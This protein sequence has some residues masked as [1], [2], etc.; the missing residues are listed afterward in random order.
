MSDDSF[1]TDPDE[2]VEQPIAPTAARNQN[3]EVE[4]AQISEQKHS[5]V[6]GLPSN[7]SRN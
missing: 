1:H 2:K 5:Q 6:A 7:S 3:Q 4:L